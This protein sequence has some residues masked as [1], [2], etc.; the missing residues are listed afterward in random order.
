MKIKYLFALLLST[1]L[2]AGCDQR[3]ANRHYRPLLAEKET[4]TV[5]KVHHTNSIPVA[6]IANGVARAV[7]AVADAMD[8]YEYVIYDNNT[9]T[10]YTASSSMPGMTYSSLSWSKSPTP[11]TDLNDAEIMQEIEVPTSD[12][13][14]A[15]TEISTDYSS[16][17]EVNSLDSMEGVPSTDTG[18]TDAGGTSDGGGGD[19]GGGGDSG[20]GDGGG[21]G[22]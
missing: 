10:F 7:E 19:A 11:P 4:V 16:I 15:A 22:D 6:Q 3:T 21:G 2:I 18:T 9:S 17:P 14:Q 13:G 8:S 1:L 5:Y 20:G 12:L